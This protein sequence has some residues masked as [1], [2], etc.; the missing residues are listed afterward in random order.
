MV[1]YLEGCETRMGCEGSIEEN[2]NGRPSILK[3]EGRAVTAR[4][5]IH[6]LCSAGSD[7]ESCVDSENE[8]QGQ[9]PVLQ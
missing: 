7:E 2:S 5:F 8:F 6:S 3:H 9:H 4:P 1:A